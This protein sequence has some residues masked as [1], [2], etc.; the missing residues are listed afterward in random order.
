MIVT[1]HGLFGHIP[2][3]IRSDAGLFSFLG[4][5]T[6]FDEFGIPEVDF[7]EAIV[8]RGNRVPEE[9]VLAAMCEAL[10]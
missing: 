6:C 3:G 1:F 5:V 2:G 10:T 4:V 7:V 8:E 9:D